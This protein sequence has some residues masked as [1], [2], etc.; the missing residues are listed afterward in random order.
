M[1]YSNSTGPGPRLSPT[2]IRKFIEISFGGSGVASCLEWR[3][4]S[5]TNSQTQMEPD[6][7]RHQWLVVYVRFIVLCMFQCSL[8]KPSAFKIRSKSK[9]DSTTIPN[10]KIQMPNCSTKYKS[11]LVLIIILNFLIE[12]FKCNLV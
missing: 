12:V 2:I 4:F 5:L 9:L 8:F 7:L 3:Q 6:R 1:K 10:S 11:N